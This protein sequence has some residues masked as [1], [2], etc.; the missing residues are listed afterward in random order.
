MYIPPFS[1]APHLHRTVRCVTGILVAVPLELHFVLLDLAEILLLNF[2]DFMVGKTV[3][4]DESLTGWWFQPLL[5]NMNVKW[6]YCSQY[7]EK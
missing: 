7:M 5:K 4:S 2:M 6:D 3:A 1:F